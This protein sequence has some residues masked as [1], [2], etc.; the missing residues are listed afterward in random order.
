MGSLNVS[1][2]A[3]IQIKLQECGVKNATRNLNKKSRPRLASRQGVFRRDS[4][5]KGRFASQI[6]EL[7]TFARQQTDSTFDSCIANQAARRQDREA[8]R[9]VHRTQLSTRDRLVAKA[10]WRANDRAVKAA[11]A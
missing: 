3:T 7:P 6:G 1:D 10:C 4:D 8:R 11:E 9:G 5:A 2:G